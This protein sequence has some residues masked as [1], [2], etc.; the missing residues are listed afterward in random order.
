MLLQEYKLLSQGLHF[1]FFPLHSPLQIP[2]WGNSVTA[3][4]QEN[5]NQQPLLPFYPKNSIVDV[6]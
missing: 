6:R 1:L 4:D 2:N 3:S 5:Q